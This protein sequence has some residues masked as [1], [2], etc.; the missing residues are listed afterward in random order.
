[1]L[2]YLPE[3]LRNYLARLGWGHGDDEL[4]TDAQAAEWFDVADVVKAPARLDWAKL[5]FINQQYIRAADND[6]LAALTLHV[7]E[8]R[9]VHAAPERKAALPAVIALVK[10]GAQTT[11]QL[12]DLTLFALKSRPLALDAKTQGMLTDETRGRLSRLRARVAEAEWAVAE[13]EGEI[14]AFAESEGVG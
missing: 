4:F 10:D 5:N 7:H 3:A 6:R 1:D 2:G 8:G 13:L 9:G 12:A 11:L 14:R